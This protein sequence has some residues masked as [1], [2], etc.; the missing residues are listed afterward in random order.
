MR[1]GVKVRGVA[2][3]CGAIATAFMT[4]KGQLQAPFAV[5]LRL[6]SIC[7]GVLLSTGQDPLGI[8]TWAGCLFVFEQ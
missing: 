7:L 2:D 4:L 1:T 6:A 8:V 5:A 3:R